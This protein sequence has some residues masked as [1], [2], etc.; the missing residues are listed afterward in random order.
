MIRHAKNP[1]KPNTDEEK[2]ETKEKIVGEM[3][4]E[5]YYDKILSGED[6]YVT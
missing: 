4:L 6:G 1:Q 5:K 3:G 2:K